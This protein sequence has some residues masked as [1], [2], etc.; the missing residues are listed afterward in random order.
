MSMH[1][2]QT[3]SSAAKSALNGPA[4]TPARQ[5]RP[6]PNDSLRNRSNE[7]L[8]PDGNIDL[9]KEN[10]SSNIPEHL[11]EL[12]EPSSSVLKCP[13][14]RRSTSAR[15][16][17]EV[18]DVTIPVL[19]SSADIRRKLKEALA[20]SEPQI[21]D[22][23]TEPHEMDVEMTPEAQ[24]EYEE[25]EEESTDYI[26]IW[27]PPRETYERHFS[28]PPLPM[29]ELEDD[30]VEDNDDFRTSK[31][32]IE[33]LNLNNSRP[34]AEQNFSSHVDLTP[35]I[36][37]NRLNE[38]DDQEDDPFGF[39]KVERR[40]QRTRNIRPRLLAINE[41][42]QLKHHQTIANRTE[43]SASS[44]SSRLGLGVSRRSSMRKRGSTRDKPKTVDFT[45]RSALSDNFKDLSDFERY[46]E[47]EHT[48]SLDS[49]KAGQQGVT[50]QSGE[51]DISIAATPPQRSWP[52]SHRYS[53]G[54]DLPPIALARTPKKTPEAG[55]PLSYKATVTS[56][57]TRREVSSSKKIKYTSTQK[58]KTLLP[59]RRRPRGDRARNKVEQVPASEDDTDE[60]ESGSDHDDLVDS[61]DYGKT[62][63]KDSLVRQRWKASGS[64][65]TPPSISKKT[66]DVIDGSMKPN[67]LRDKARE[68]APKDKDKTEESGWSVAQ[69]RVQ[70]ERIQY[71]KEVDD[72][73]L[74]VETIR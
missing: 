34:S 13:S 20:T 73:Q 66:M 74:E 45:E 44:I 15:I 53:M 56:R 69:R 50:D 32:T 10:M 62:S 7:T 4:P 17:K 29:F 61:D 5:R 52:R 51:P 64:K 11:T 46:M 9:D 58:L 59:K 28:P 36:T 65:T 72:F 1:A 47:I 71:F 54:L 35:D 18:E 26:L 30:D 19:P 39:T 70:Q 3:R 21:V 43:S 16:Q 12:D 2:R 41:Q 23:P 40:L 57:N 27:S 14:H 25:Y 60:V 37:E 24:C 31:L 22:A 67:Q 42:R 33:D 68:Q 55:M 63:R 38:E 48:G 6:Q 49:P 8:V